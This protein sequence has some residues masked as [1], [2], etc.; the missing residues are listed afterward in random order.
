VPKASRIFRILDDARVR[1]A[2]NNRW[3]SLCGLKMTGDVFLPQ[4]D[5]SG[6]IIVRAKLPWIS[7]ERWCDGKPISSVSRRN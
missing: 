5:A 6:M 1:E 3:R 7:V 2:L 4:F